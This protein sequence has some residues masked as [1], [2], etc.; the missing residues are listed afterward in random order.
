MQGA[1]V[2]CASTGREVPLCQGP[3]SVASVSTVA[4]LL[5]ESLGPF[6]V[7][8]S[9]PPHLF[10]EPRLEVGCTTPD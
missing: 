8:F 1:L 6:W 7:L 4:V 10:M 9:L 2:H 5:W 3:D